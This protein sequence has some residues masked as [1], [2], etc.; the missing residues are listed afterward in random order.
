M[1]GNRLAKEGQRWAT[2]PDARRRIDE[3]DEI[4]GGPRIARSHAAYANFGRG[5][6]GESPRLQRTRRCGADTTAR[7]IGGLGTVGVWAAAR[8]RALG[9]VS[10]R[11][12]DG[13]RKRPLLWLLSGLLSVFL[14]A[15]VVLFAEY[16]A[17]NY[18]RKLLTW[19]TLGAQT[20]LGE[21]KFGSPNPREGWLTLL[22]TLALF[23]N[24]PDRRPY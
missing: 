21:E 17:G 12:R 14:L 19:I 16:A 24:L 2:V 20:A 22:G 13:Y 11:A 18:E 1:C 9:R 4:L 15:T 5:P 7:L 3:G 8:G 10:G 6:A 23:E